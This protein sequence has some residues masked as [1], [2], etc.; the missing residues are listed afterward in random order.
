MITKKMTIARIA[1]QAPA[2]NLV[3][4]TITN[5]TAVMPRPKVLIARERIHLAAH[6]GVRLGLQVPGPVPDHPELAEVERHEDAD[7]VELDQPGGLGVERDDQDDRHDGQEDDAVAVGQP[8]AARA[9]RPGREAVAGED[10]AEHREAVE[11]RVGGQHQDD[12]R[13]RDHE[14][15]ARREVVE[16]RLGQLGDHGV[17]VVAGGQRLAVAVAQPVESF[18]S[19]YRIPISLA[20]AMMLSSMV[21]AIVPRSSSVVAALRLLGLP[22]RGDAVG[23]RLD[24]GERGAAGRERAGQQERSAPI[25]SA[26][27]VAGRRRDGRGRRSRPAAGRRRRPAAARRAPSP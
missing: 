13:H 14:V 2:K 26:V 23:D 20:S 1:I 18:G 10:R 5:T 21:I 27:L 24:A 19:T 17:L 12:P 3:T 7:D 22:E 4:S 16:D 8:V 11:R 15:E 6:R 25:W 9:Q